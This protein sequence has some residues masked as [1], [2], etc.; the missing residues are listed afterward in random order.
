M[1]DMKDL[2]SVHIELRVNRVHTDFQTA[3]ERRIEALVESQIMNM[4]KIVI[5][6][7]TGSFLKT[8]YNLNLR[9][10]LKQ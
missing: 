5:Q 9:C 8:N 6:I 1:L 4:S 3:S 7:R 10:K 2:P